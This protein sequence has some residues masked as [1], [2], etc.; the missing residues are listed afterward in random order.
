M[1]PEIIQEKKYDNRVDVWA[2]GVITYILM[3]GKPPF[4][5]KSKEHILSSILANNLSFSNPIWQ[6]ISRDAIDFI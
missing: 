2:I 4:G 6:A 5:G 1:A 3:S